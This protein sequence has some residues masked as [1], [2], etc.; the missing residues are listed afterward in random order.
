[1]CMYSQDSGPFPCPLGESL[2]HDVL[3]SFEGPDMHVVVA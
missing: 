2:G 1:M 3:Q